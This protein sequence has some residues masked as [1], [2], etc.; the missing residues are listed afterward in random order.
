MLDLRYYGDPVLRRH[1]GPVKRFDPELTQLADEMLEIMYASRG[2]GL[3]APQVGVLKRLIVVDVSD[4]HDEPVVMVNPRIIRRS[5]ED[6]DTE[7]CL[8]IPSI[9]VEVSRSKEIEVIFQDLQERE[10]TLRGKGLW[11]RV[12]QHEVDHLDGRLIVDY[13]DPGS[14]ADFE[15]TWP[16]VL[17]R[18]RARRAAGGRHDDEGEED[19]ETVTSGEAGNT[20]GD[21]T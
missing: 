15:A 3:A 16:E 8:S 14:R 18:E 11:A 17:E 9:Q 6:S 10:R 4:D 2:I 21:L 13:M 5:G 19:G 7:G 1:T 20:E 12:V